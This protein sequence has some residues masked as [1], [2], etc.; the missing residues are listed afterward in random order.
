MNQNKERLTHLD[1]V[2]IEVCCEAARIELTL[3]EA[4]KL[5]TGNVIQFG[6]LVGEA[7]DIRCNGH[8]FAAG[9]TVVVDDRMA[10]RVTRLV[11]YT[12]EVS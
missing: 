5:K 7:F 2:H 10:V 11:E 12:E 1:D 3:A 8:L 4:R 6:K 9:E